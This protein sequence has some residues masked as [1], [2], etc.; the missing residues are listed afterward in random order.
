MTPKSPELLQAQAATFAAERIEH[1][2]DS[3]HVLNNL[4]EL[5]I[6]NLADV[7]RVTESAE[8]HKDE[9]GE[10]L[11]VP[12]NTKRTVATTSEYTDFLRSVGG[13]KYEAIQGRADMLTQ[14]NQVFKPIVTGLRAEL[15][16][17]ATRKEHPA[18]M[19]NGSNS[20]VFRITHEGKDYAVR[21]PSGTKP[22]PST[23][24]SHLAGA[25]LGKGVPHLEQI[26]AASYEDGVTVAEVMP[27]KEMGKDMTLEDVA[28]ITDE[29]L[30]GLVDT[31]TAVSE[32]GIEIDPKPTNIFYDR[33]AGFGI[34]D[35]HSSK[36]AAKNSADQDLGTI[37][38]WMATPIMNAGFYG[39]YNPEMTADDYA[40][41]ANKMSANL[42]VLKRF[43][44]V[45]ES[46][47]DGE[48]RETALKDIDSR[49]ESGQESI[50]NYLNPEYVAD[51]MASD[52]E[53]KRQM[54]ERANQKKSAADTWMT[55]DV[56]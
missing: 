24:D 13:S 32:R 16:D 5:A 29:Q 42:G 11:R 39:G 54:A 12:E 26:V 43:R 44:V 14:Y 4:G 9:A 2:Q 50:D 48:D 37:V 47:L 41:D 6:G 25:V 22:S 8:Y 20:A 52:A 31:L 36:V 33:E 51:R 17:P 34:V 7:T 30:S 28:A 18:F 19:G 40:Q 53:R 3:G 27:G 23:I 55:L 21:V 1:Y 49:I 35:Y 15:Q 10:R 45:V 38:G 56:V 46:K